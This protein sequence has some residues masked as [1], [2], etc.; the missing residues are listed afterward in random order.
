VQLLY[1]QMKKACSE[2][3]STKASF[4]CWLRLLA[5]HNAL[6][7]YQFHTKTARHF[8][9]KNC[10]R[11]PFHRKRLLPDYFGGKVHCLDGFD[12]EGITVRRAAGVAMS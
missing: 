6:T 10:G 4:V 8:F 5:G 3:R 9:C 1:L 11:Y 12:P 7:E 2:S